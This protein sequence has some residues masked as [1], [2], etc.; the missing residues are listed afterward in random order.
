MLWKS[1]QPGRWPVTLCRLRQALPIICLMAS[2][3]DLTRQ[4]T[5]LMPSH[6]GCCAFW[7]GSAKILL[8]A[9]QWGLAYLAHGSAQAVADHSAAW[10]LSHVWTGTSP[11]TADS[12][13]P[14]YKNTKYKN[15][16]GQWDKMG[17]P[18]TRPS[19]R[20]GRLLYRLVAFQGPECLHVQAPDPVP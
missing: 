9:G 6:P 3:H 14:K 15:H 5:P 4:L 11:T 7:S 20:G 10:V 19:S 1:K 2:G 8:R 12:K 16:A 17:L 13:Y 18:G